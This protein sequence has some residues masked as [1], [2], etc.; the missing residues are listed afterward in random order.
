MKTVLVIDDLKSFDFPADWEV[1]YART[2]KDGME[3]LQ[4]IMYLPAIESPEEFELWLDHD[5]GGDDTIRPLCL[6]LAEMAFYGVSYPF[7][8]IVLCSHNPVGSKWIE[9][10]LNPYYQVA[11]LY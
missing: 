5:L 10:T 8:R 9:S 11:R 4:R 3:Y 1:I 6:L 7:K 2:L